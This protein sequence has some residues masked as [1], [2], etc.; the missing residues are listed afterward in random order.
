MVRSDPK[1]T[2][3]E[4]HSLQTVLLVNS[5]FPSTALHSRHTIPYLVTPHTFSKATLTGIFIFTAHADS[6]LRFTKD[7]AIGGTGQAVAEAAEGKGK[8]LKK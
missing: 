5:E 3:L 1:P 8:D 2:R 7:G 6:R 4:V